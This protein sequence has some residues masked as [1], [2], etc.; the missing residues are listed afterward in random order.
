MKKILLLLLCPLFVMAAMLMS[1]Q[2][3]DKVTICHIPPDNPTNPQTITVKASSLPSHLAHGDTIGECTTAC[4]SN[5][6]PCDTPSLS[7]S[8]CCGGICSGEGICAAECTIGQ[9]LGP[10][11]EC[12]I[13]LPCCPEAEV[14]DT[15]PPV[16]S[17]GVCILGG[18]FTESEF[19]TCALLGE[20]CDEDNG[21]F[22]C[23]DYNCS[24]FVCVEP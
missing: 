17:G 5:G 2:G 8:E 4:K 23:F 21:N 1:A 16:F 14:P 18:C 9:E 10:P 6:V 20:A 12:T 7:S 24:D 22:C 19:P 13:D 15:D 11:D 3:V